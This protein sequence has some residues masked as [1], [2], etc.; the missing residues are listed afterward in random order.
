MNKSIIAVVAAA[1]RNNENKILITKRPSNSHLGGLWEFPGGKIDGGETPEHALQRELLEELGV[2][3]ETKKLLW[4]ETFTYPEKTIHIRFFECG[5]LEAAE[6]IKPIQVA[7]FKWVPIEAL[8][9][10]EFPP[11]DA[12][13]IE[14]LVSGV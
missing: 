5:L 8:S 12:A 13:F 3:T 1:I 6:N 2:R 11:A 4:Q 10:F 7:D 14:R 9:Q